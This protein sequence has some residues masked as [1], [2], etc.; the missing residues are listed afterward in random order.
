[1]K[2]RL[3]NLYKRTLGRY[4]STMRTEKHKSARDTLALVKKHRTDYCTI[5]YSCQSFYENDSGLLPRITSIAVCS[6]STW[7]TKSFSMH[8]TAAI[9]K[10]PYEEIPSRYDDIEREMLKAYFTYLKQDTRTKYVHWNMRSANY[11]FAAIESRGEL[12]CPAE[13]YIL[14]DE[15]KVDL[16]KTLIGLYGKKYIPHPQF[17]SIIE[18]NYPKPRNFLT[19][20]DEAQ[21]FEKG[22]YVKMHNSTLTK[23]TNMSQILE[24][25]MANKL[26]TNAKLKDIYGVSIEGLIEFLRRK[27]QGRLFLFLLGTFVAAL[28][29]WLFF[30]N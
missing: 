27:W 16:S 15:R 10:V 18:K 17:Q 1:M 6:I 28:I 5:H 25:A 20:L 13:V 3:V 19:G 8:I 11:G 12:L 26:K 23:V 9:M 24:L 21:A 2:M 22:E 30:G 14:P 7:Q 4:T 29:G